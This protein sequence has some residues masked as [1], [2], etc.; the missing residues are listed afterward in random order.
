MIDVNTWLMGLDEGDFN[1]AARAIRN[2]IAGVGD[3][4]EAS[5]VHADLVRDPT[6]REV[7]LGGDTLDELSD[8]YRALLALTCDIMAGL[9]SG[10]SD[11]ENAVGIVLIDEIGAHLHPRLRMQIVAR[12]RYIFPQIQFVCSTHE[13]LCL[14]GLFDN[15][16]DRIRRVDGIV[17]RETIDRNPSS[18]RIDQLLTSE[19]FGLESTIDPEIDGEFQLYYHLLSKDELSEEDKVIVGRARR[20]QRFLSQPFFVAETFTGFPGKYVP[21]EK[22]IESFEAVVAG[23]HDHLPEQAFYMVGDIEEAEAKARELEG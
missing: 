20:I 3:Q 14:R 22:T 1:V 23:D 13:P 5:R 11:M 9:G 6:L 18:Y 4:E 19:F 8:G 17:G 10:L 21:L 15:E 2:L 7:T 16:V 12:L